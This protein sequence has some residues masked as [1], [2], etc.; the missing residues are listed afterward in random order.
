MSYWEK[1][2][3]AEEE[4]ASEIAR[5]FSAVQ[6]ECYLDALERIED[7]LYKLYA[8]VKDKGAESL[9]RSQLYQYSRYVSLHNAISTEVYGI[10]RLQENTIMKSVTEVFGKVREVPAD[11]VRNKELLQQL[12]Q[13]KWS[14]K[15]YSERVWHNAEQLANKLQD[16]ITDLLVL[17][18]DSDTIK[19]EIEKQFGVSL[20]AA[21][22]L[23]RTETSHAYNQA[24][25][26]RYTDMGV[27]KIEL[28]IEPD[29]CEKCLIYDGKKFDLRNV[30]V[31]PIHPNCRCTY[32]PIID[33]EDKEESPGYYEF[34]KKI[35]PSDR[36]V[37]EQTLREFEEEA[38]H[39]DIETACVILSNGVVYKSYGISDRIFVEDQFG[40]RLKDAIVS[41]NHPIAETHFSFSHDD[42]ILFDRFN[43]KELYGFDEKYFYRLTRTPDGIDELP[44]ELDYENDGHFHS[45]N[46]AHQYHISYR[47]WRR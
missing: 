26:Q 1:R 17:G 33:E 35:D 42:F 9:T 23:L 32:L 11:V 29:A 37:I 7:E 4:G 25:L 19:N 47:R 45:I 38:I 31:I 15:N 18:K 22:R 44:T 41:H 16:A 28:L 27:D 8:Q 3:K 10:A 21:D 12:L 30:P 34:L 2:I 6:K 36:I 24:A 14:G 39:A 13:S 46:R 20:S 40:E 43:L 5:H